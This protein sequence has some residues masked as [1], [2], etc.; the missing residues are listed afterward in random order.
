MT[1]KK[2]EKLREVGPLYKR[3]AAFAP[4]NEVEKETRRLLLELARAR[5]SELR[6]ELVSH[7]KIRKKRAA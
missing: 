6:R 5:R 1:F 7:I 3:I 4:T 2:T